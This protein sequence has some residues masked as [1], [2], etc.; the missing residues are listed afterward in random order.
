MLLKRSRVLNA[1]VCIAP[2]HLRV[3]DLEQRARVLA[4]TWFCVLCLQVRVL[5]K[6]LVLH[7][8]MFV[9]LRVW[10]GFL[11]LWQSTRGCPPN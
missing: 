2:K 1:F 5:R 4:N 8:G 9:N 10:V 11:K 7:F 3:L 6:R